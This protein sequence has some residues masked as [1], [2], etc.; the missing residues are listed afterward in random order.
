MEMKLRV[1]GAKCFKGEVEGT[2]YDSTTVRVEMPV[3]RSK[4]TECGHD[5]VELKYGK[6]DRFAELKALHH[7][8]CDCYVD[9]EPSSKGFDLLSLR[10]VESAKSVKAA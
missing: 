2:F 5:V 8:P 4:E 7:F 6:S 9:I 3:P 1:L 10:P